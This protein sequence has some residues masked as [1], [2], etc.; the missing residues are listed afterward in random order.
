MSRPKVSVLMAIYNAAEHLEAAIDSILNQTFTD[1]ELILVDDCSTDESPA[2]LARYQTQ[3]A[4][5]VLLRNDHNLGLT[6]SLNLGLAIAQGDCVARMDADDIALPNRL[7]AQ[8]NYILTH[9]EV[10]IVGTSCVLIDANNKT[11]GMRSMPREDFLIRW[12]SLLDNPFVHSTVMWQRNRFSANTNGDPCYD[13]SLY[14]TQDYDLWARL[15]QQAQGHNLPTPLLYYRVHQ[16]ITQ[17]NRIEQLNN[18][19]MISQQIIQRMLPDFKISLTTVRQLR[20]CWI[21]HE[22]LSGEQSSISA[23]YRTLIT[24]YLNLKDAFS[25]AYLTPDQ[26]LMLNH[27][28][29]LNILDM[30]LRLPK[31]TALGVEITKH[32]AQSPLSLPQLVWQKIKHRY[33]YRLLPNS[34]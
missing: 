5:I 2:L 9:P 33:A 22:G 31:T 17:K 30:L 14:T 23:T 18:H 24:D 8:L 34:I 25:T 12:T 4:R 3:D 15:L 27:Q 7:D 26:K 16:S 28:V 1:F 32:L 20:Q 29:N 11:V 13:T 19:D 21:C 6:R 10:G